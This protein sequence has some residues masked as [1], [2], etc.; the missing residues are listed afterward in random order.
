[1]AGR[2]EDTPIPRLLAEEELILDATE[3]LAKAMDAAG[4]ER[5]R[6]ATLMSVPP[7]RVTRM[8]RGDLSV[9]DLAA[10]LHVLGL[11]AEI[12]LAPSAPAPEDG[13]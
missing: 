2:G 1:M 10:A 9:R 13:P 5:C 6:L 3:T 4:V 12:T 8:L 11:R 7:S